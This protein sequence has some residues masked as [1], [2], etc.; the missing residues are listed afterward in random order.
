MQKFE[1]YFALKLA[2]LLFSAVEQFSV[3]VQAKDI[4]IQEA[5]NGAK[6]L[7][8]Y[9][10]S[11]RNETKFDLVYNTVYHDSRNL[12]E[13]PSLPRPRKMP[14]RLDDGAASHQ[15]QNPKERY[16]HSYFETLELAVGEV[17]RR[18]DQADLI[19]IQEIEVLLL[20]AGNGETIDSIPPVI[21]S[22]LD[23][24]LDQ[25]RLKTQLSLVCDMIKTA[26][27]QVKKVTNVRTIAETMNKSAIYKCMLGEVD[28]LLQLYFT[29]P[30]TTATAE[31]S[32]SSLRRIKTFLRSS[33]THCRLNNLFLLYIHTSRTDQLDLSAIAAQFV[34][35]HSRRMCY[36]GK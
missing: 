34:S 19:T 15:Y 2:Y 14:R 11:L 25:D 18:F 6:L 31:R 5:V 9:L 10:K 7:A 29:F 3:N 16:R 8:T 12:T 21:Q 30:V 27:S 33:M 28:K 26:S 13:E 20:R 1:T 4:T 23:K 24:D 36:F 35:V 17:E 22:Y 32:F